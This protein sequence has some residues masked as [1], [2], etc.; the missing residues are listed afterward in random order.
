MIDLIAVL[1]K[2]TTSALF[3]GILILFSNNLAVAEV[4][5]LAK[6]GVIDLR[7]I[8]LS[9]ARLPL[10]GQWRFYDHQL[11]TPEKMD[12]SLS[13]V[14]DFPKLWNRDVDSKGG[15]GYA[16]YSLKILV[17]KDARD[18]ALEIPQMYSSYQ[19][20]VNGQ[21]IAVNG[22]TGMSEEETTPQ[23]RP[24]TI[25]F[26]NDQDT[27]EIVMTIANFHHN[28]GGIKESIYI[29]GDEFMQKHHQVV[30]TSNLVEFLML[31]FLSL[32]FIVTYFV[33]ERKLIILYF[34]LLC[35]T[36]AVR[37]V[38]SN[39]YLAISIFP[40]FDWATMVRI[41]Y[42]TL[43]LTMI[44]AILYLGKLFTREGNPIIKYLFVIANVLFIVFTLV[45][46][47]ANFTQWLQIYLIFV[48]LLLIY[49]VF[50][51]LWA[52][53][54]ERVGARTLLT[55][56]SLGIFIFAYDLLAYKD[57][58]K[59]NAVVFSAGY[60]TLFLL[61]SVALLLHLNII[62][63]KPKTMDMLRYE[64]LYQNEKK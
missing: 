48:A 4:Q 5:P 16:S 64:D 43:Y 9:G 23:W 25:S 7:N 13:S 45:L 46:T 55:A 12:P 63:S 42:I 1:K 2:T 31:T 33:K 3:A 40:D 10:N 6:G 61:M 36:W 32:F 26:A 22:K 47:P 51:V 58:F 41:E 34:A 19:L 24:Q 57:F 14:T 38:F 60:I 50:V 59:F 15:M 8:P 11:L 20:W 28:K 62:K 17:S 54:N 52:L 27:I 37:S 44:W 18:L 21:L 53:I 56:T 30:W 35:L 39:Q 29:G 49:G